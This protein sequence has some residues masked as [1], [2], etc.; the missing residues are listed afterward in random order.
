M[1]EARAAAFAVHA[2]AYA[3]KAAA[4]HAVPGAEERDWQHRRLPKQL[5]PAVFPER[6]DGRRRAPAITSREPGSL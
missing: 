2:A 5:R 4:Q 1:T 3:L 6:R